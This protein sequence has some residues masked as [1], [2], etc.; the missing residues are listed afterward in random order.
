MDDNPFLNKRFIKDIKRSF[1]PSQIFNKNKYGYDIID[2]NFKS[3]RNNIIQISLKLL[4][5]NKYEYTYMYKN[6]FIKENEHNNKNLMLID[7]D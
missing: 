5:G 4:N 6:E 7:K 3:K 1:V 2:I